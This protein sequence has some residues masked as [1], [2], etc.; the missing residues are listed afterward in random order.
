MNKILVFSL[1]VLLIALSV[2]GYFYNEL[3]SD[4]NNIF[5]ILSDKRVKSNL[6]IDNEYNYDYKFINDNGLFISYEILKEIIDSSVELSNSKSRV[7]IEINKLAFRLETDELTKYV[8]DNLD[9]INIPIKYIEEKKYINLDLLSKL[10]PIFYNYYE[11][12]NV[13]YINTNIEKIK[14]YSS[15]NNKNVYYLEEDLLIKFDELGK[16]SEFIY[17]DNKVIKSDKYSKII[18]SKGEIGYIIA[19]NTNLIDENFSKENRLNEVREAEQLDTISLMW[20]SISKYS[21]LKNFNVDKI[22]NLNVISPTWF[23]LNIDGIVINEA[24]LKYIDDSHKNGYQVWALYKNSFDP[25]WTNQLLT[26]EEYIDKSIAQIVFYSSLYNIDGIN[27]DFENIYLKNKDAL[28][29]YVRK[30][31]KYTKMQ[32]LTLS[33]DA[34]VP[35]GSDQYSK[36]IDREAI[37]DYVDYFML[38]AYDEHWSSSPKSGSVASIPWVIKGI[39]GTLE[40]VNNDKLVL[41]VPLYMRVWTEKNRKVLS[42]EAY[43]IKNIGSYLE[44]IDYEIIYDEASGQNYIETTKK[45]NTIKIWIEDK[46]SLIKRINLINEYNLKGIAGW[47]KGYEESYYY[48]LIDIYMK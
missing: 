17:L 32:N 36:V 11:S 28:T 29:D 33:I 14:K 37:I 13:L 45:G 3:K 18:T 2:L 44:K 9:K 35:G 4:Y 22:E 23:A 31:R 6:I 27:I 43:A 21:D 25:V 38:M 1:I 39:E 15:N 7:Y 46:E 10:Y 26:N 20:D 42:S 48:D 30:L 8:N 5:E 24:S 16:N 12:E 47:R 34:V 41:G 40:N 19:E